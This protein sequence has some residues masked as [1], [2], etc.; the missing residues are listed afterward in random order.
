[1]VMVS[2]HSNRVLRQKLGARDWGTAVIGQAM[3]LFGRIW[4]ILELWTIKVIGYFKQALKGH[5]SRNMEGN[6]GE[7]DMNC[8]IRLKRLQRRRMRSLEIDLVIFW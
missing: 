3:L 1:M 4:N 2:L 5:F 7:G 8:G 6:A